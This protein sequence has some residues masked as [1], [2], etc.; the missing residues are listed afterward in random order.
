MIAYLVSEGRCLPVSQGFIVTE[1]NAFM[2][3]H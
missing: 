3:K 1:L 2:A